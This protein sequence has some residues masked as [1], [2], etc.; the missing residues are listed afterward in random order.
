MTREHAIGNWFQANAG[1]VDA[2]MRGAHLTNHLRTYEELFL[3]ADRLAV[4]T[5]EMLDESATRKAVL[6]EALRKQHAATQQL[7]AQYGI[8]LTETKNEEC[9]H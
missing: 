9:N 5:A 2:M 7:A 3:S 8:D 6:A 4:R 1:V